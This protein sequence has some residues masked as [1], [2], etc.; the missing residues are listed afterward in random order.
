M[1]D[2]RFLTRNG[3]A[4]RRLAAE[5]LNQQP[6]SRLPR[7]RD[8]A[9]R[10]G[11]GNGTV[12]AALQLLE[13]TG[14]VRTEAR[15]H[16]GTY[17]REVD[18]AGLW[19]LAGLGTMLAAMPLPYSRRYEGLATGLRAAFED[20]GIPFA[21]T[22]MRGA[23]ARLDALM[24]GKVDL[25]AV[26][27]LAFEEFGEGFPIARLAD[28]GPRTY[29][30]AHGVLLRAGV[31]LDDPDLAVAVDT[32]SADQQELTRLVFSGRSVRYVETSYM[33][34][35]E[36]FRRGEVDA[37]VWNL[38][39]V[40]Q[41][42]DEDCATIPFDELTSADLADRNS[43]AVLAVRADDSPALEAVR[44]RISADLVTRTQRAVLTG[45]RL[46]SY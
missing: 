20:A 3:L 23:Q 27:R 40:H 4:A 5:L 19:Q 31:S 7:I 21:L 11:V 8:Y 36:L 43:S 45:D 26:S 29:V 18:R 41:H 2:A 35:G 32:S 10:L 16:L 6:D 28:L 33:Q 44:G 9:Q 17:L 42:I 46:P 12:Q 15:G 30:G 25:I 1:L 14:A 37:S 34:L 22:F 13:N 24:D 39:E 38:D